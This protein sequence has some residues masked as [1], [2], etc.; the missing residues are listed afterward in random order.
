[1][2]RKSQLEPLPPARLQGAR[3]FSRA[4]FAGR[5]ARKGIDDFFRAI[6]LCDKAQSGLMTATV[7]VFGRVFIGQG[8]AL[9]GKLQGCCPNPSLF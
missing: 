4:C 1:M 2:L 5:G 9:R 3:G 6:W 8:N 7:V